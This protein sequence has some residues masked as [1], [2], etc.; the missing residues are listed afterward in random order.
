[1]KL[2]GLLIA[3]Q[4]VTGCGGGP[5]STPVSPT[6]ATAQTQ[7]QTPAQPAPSSVISGFAVDTAFRPLPGARVE[8]VDGPSAGTSTTADALGRFSLW[9][10]FDATTTFRASKDG[11]LAATQTWRCSVAVCRG[12]TGANPWL[13]FSL[14]VPAA[15]VS[16]AGDYTLTIAATEA[17]TALP[18]GVRLRTYAATIAPRVS[19]YSPAGTLFEVLIRDVPLAF[20]DIYRIT[21]GV[22]GDHV[23]FGLYGDHNPFLVERVTSNELLAFSGSAPGVSVGT[24]PAS[25]IATSFEGLIEYFSPLTPARC[26]AKNHR[27]TLTRR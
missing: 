10:T 7:P 26:E 22:A 25:T 8:I 13:G 15:P 2:V 4:F 17:C 27:F 6:P 23:G 19:A 21:L 5:V 18:A 11:Y 12:L 1:M 24:S 20:E 9:G 16:I 3:A 14:A